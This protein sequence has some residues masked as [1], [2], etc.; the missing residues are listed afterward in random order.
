MQAYDK[1]RFF[2]VFGSKGLEYNQKVY[3][4]HR[5]NWKDGDW[6]DDSDQMILILRTLVENNGKV[7]VNQWHQ[8]MSFRLNNPYHWDNQPIK[9]TFFLGSSLMKKILQES[10]YTG[11]TM[12][13]KSLVIQVAVV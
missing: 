11:C 9:C 10:C 13:M 2:G 8:L 6:T 3:D 1:S 7:S 12:V 5:R 4:G